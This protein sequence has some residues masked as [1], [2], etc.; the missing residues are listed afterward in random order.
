MPQPFLS[1]TELQAKRKKYLAPTVKHWYAHPPHFVRG[2]MQWLYD[3]TGKQYLDFFGGI[4]TVSVGHCNTAV[5]EAVVA[6][7]KVLQHTSTILLSQPMIDLSERLANLT[8]LESAK[9][10]ITNSGTEANEMAILLAKVAT[11]HG[12]I[13]A[14]RHSYHG[15]SWLAASLTSHA[16]FRVDPLPV[17]GIS[18]VPNAYCYR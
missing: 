18:F 10:L 13:L 4:C 6:Q 14:L 1:A 8:S 15:R 16:A 12:E 2:E 3:E 7:A 17:P 5:T 11:G 9:C